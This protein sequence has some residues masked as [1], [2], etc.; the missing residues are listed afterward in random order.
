VK[1]PIKTTRKG[2]ANLRNSG[3]EKPRSGGRDWLLALGLLAAVVLAYEPAWNGKPVWDD[4]AHHIR[5]ALQSW[6]GLERI[7][8]EP[9]A[10]QQFYPLVYSVLWLEQKV[11]ADAPAGYHI[12]NILLH[13]VS[14]LLL[15]KVL[16]RME[17]PGA[18]L[19]AALW[20]L[21]PVQ[22][23]SVAWMSEL[24][25]TLSGLCYLGSALAYLRFDRERRGW[26]YLASLGLFGAGLLAKSVI[27][28]LPAALL[29]V[30]WWKRKKLRWKEDVLPLGPFFVV[31][32]GL[33][34]FTAWMERT[35]V[36]GID[37]GSHLSGVDRCFVPSRAVWFYLGKLAWPHPLIFMY[38]R[39][40]V[41]A[42]VWWQYLFPGALLL[43]AAGLW[44]WRGRLGFGPLVAL[45]FFAGTLFPA[46]GFVDVYPFRYSFVADHF[47]YLACLGPLALAGAGIERGLGWAA[48]ST[49]LFK[50]TGCAVLLAVLG[51]LTWVQCG[52]Y[53]DV[54]TLWRMTVA[55][56]PGCWMAQNELGV[57]RL[58]QGKLDEAASRFKI[59]LDLHPDDEKAHDNLG[60]VLSRQGAVGEA[61]EHFRKGLAIQPADPKARDSL[62]TL[63]FQQGKAGE[64]IAEYQKALA[65]QPDFAEVRDHLGNAL[66]QQGQAGEA[67]AQFRLALAL[68]P[69]LANAHYNLGNAL[70]QQGAIVEAIAHFRKALEIQ[71]NFAEARNNLGHALLLQGEV[72]EAIAQFRKALEIQP[73]YA[74][75]GR[76]LGRALLRQGDFGGALACF[77]KTIALPPDAAQKWH[78]LGDD[79]LQQ[80]FLIEAIACYRQALSINPRFAQ[81]WA[82]L[83]MACFNNGQWKEAG[84]SWQKSLEINPAQPQIQNNLASL[85]ATASDASLRDGP[86]A[87]ALAEQANQSAGGANPIILCTLAAAYAEGGN[88][89]L[90]AATARRALELAVQ[91]KQ[92]SLAATLQ[93]QI[94]LYETNA[95]LRKAPR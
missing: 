71:P 12:V 4:D 8:F 35:M 86:R 28:T 40:E 1:S 94:K 25:N 64:A 44:F 7:W 13:A 18:W 5:P 24:K 34:L 56:N 48:K 32:I 41:S 21:H 51:A 76:N 37:R 63:L 90:A 75:A 72:V 30:F 73:D 50:A 26:C 59:V 55:R 93:E 89:P 31:G 23:E 61:I 74:Q 82:G 6:K 78:D 68:Q 42:A 22:V 20:A 36:I 49:P 85:L 39:W 95:P 10:T 38:P 9:G 46:L 47:Q 54:E 79:F 88:F 57:I 58:A 67:I 14:A 27:A 80:G 52:Q 83:G 3:D 66:L 84:E 62:G 53:S 33:G 81:A 16:R 60:T 69:D 92:D 70:L 15:V 87:V 19:G 29:L 43:L 65:L 91:Q 2:P 45:L 17:V 11:W 77:E